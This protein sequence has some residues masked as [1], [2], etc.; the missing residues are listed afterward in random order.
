MKSWPLIIVISIMTLT[1]GCSRSPKT[2]IIVDYPLD[3]MANVISSNNIV[4]DKDI[5]SDGKGSLKIEASSPVTISLLNVTNLNLDNVRLTYSARVRTQ[6]VIGQ[7]YLE[8]YSYASGFPT[9]ES[10]GQATLQSG[11]DG[12][13]DQETT[14]DLLG[15]VKPD[16]IMLSL[17]FNGTGTAWID[18][19]KL[20]SGPLP[21]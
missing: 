19:I 9:L 21:K 5:S 12:W 2:K 4:F 6:K 7:V 10:R 18:D 17:A 14:L 11:T 13:K 16:S 1:V 20:T 3:N 15:P 8:M